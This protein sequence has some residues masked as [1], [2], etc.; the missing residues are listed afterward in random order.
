MVRKRKGLRDFQKSCSEAD[1]CKNISGISAQ[2]MASIIS[3]TD[4]LI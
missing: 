4:G 2:Q 3:A 1:N